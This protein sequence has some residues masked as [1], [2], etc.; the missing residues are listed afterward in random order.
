MA[1][2]YNGVQAHILQKNS[3]A[4]FVPC[5][6]QCLILA[7]VPAA[8]INNAAVAF[9]GTVQRFFTFLSSSTSRWEMSMNVLQTSLK[10]H[11]GTW[12]TSKTSAV[13]VLYSQIIEEC[14]C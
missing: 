10:D 5:A 4:R 13:K 2:K 3:F 6:A 7:G 14:K 11:S 8:S 1:A 9:F 12:W